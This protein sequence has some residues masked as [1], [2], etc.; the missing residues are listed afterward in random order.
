MSI[1]YAL[2]IASSILMCGLLFLVAFIGP[3]MS[4]C[5]K[6]WDWYFHWRAKRGTR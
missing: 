1:E 3:L 4:L 5:F 2:V 6:F